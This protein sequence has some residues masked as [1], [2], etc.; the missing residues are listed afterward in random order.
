MFNKSVIR[1]P[2]LYETESC[3]REKRGD[4]M[5]M[6]EEM[7]GVTGRDRA[8]NEVIRGTVKVIEFTKKLQEGRSLWC[9]RIMRKEDE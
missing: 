8:R 6:L 5:R 2:M 1:P 4:K 3:P 9:G 7:C